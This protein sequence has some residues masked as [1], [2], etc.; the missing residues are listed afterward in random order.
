MRESPTVHPSAQIV[1]S[2]LG[3]WCFV[4]EKV[5]MLEV[6]LGDYSYVMRF[7]SLA[8]SRVGK[9]CSIAAFT[10]INPGNHPLHRVTTHHLTYRRRMYQLDDLDDEEFFE[11]RRSNAVE[12]GHDV[13]IGH[14]AIILPGVKIGTGA[15]VGAGSVVT[16]D[17]PPYCIVAGVPARRI[18]E[19]FP[20]RIAERLMAVAWWDWSRELLERRWRDFDDV[21]LFLEKYGS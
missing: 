14:G 5:E 1:K 15:V 12:L 9:F 21:E 11:W 2:S 18:R 20:R 4:D 16:K 3:K 19:R 13:W 10:R 7:S 17:V 8:Y 6:S